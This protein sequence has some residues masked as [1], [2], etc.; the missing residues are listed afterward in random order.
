MHLQRQFN[1]SNRYPL[2]SLTTSSVA[3]IS[4]LC[5]FLHRKPN[6]KTPSRQSQI[7]PQDKLLNQWM[8]MRRRSSYQICKALWLPNKSHKITWWVDTGE[9]TIW[10]ILNSKWW[11]SSSTRL[12]HP[13]GWWADIARWG[14]MTLTRIWE[15]DT[16]ACNRWIWWTMA[17]LLNRSSNSSLLHQLPSTSLEDL[18]LLRSLSNSHLNNKCSNKT[19]TTQRCPPMG[20][21]N[22]SPWQLKTQILGFSATWLRMV[23]TWTSLSLRL[24]L[25]SRICTEIMVPIN[26]NISSSKNS[27]QMAV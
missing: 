22:S 26:S 8:P 19:N 3:L 14:T 13:G 25:N 16:V 23:R 18:N 17:I 9:T 27:N 10:W 21:N 15:E 2:P 5:T 24:Q 20:S 6:N 12:P 11:C 4:P 1:H 7:L